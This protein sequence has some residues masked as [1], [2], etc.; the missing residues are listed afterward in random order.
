VDS[1]IIVVDIGS[2]LIGDEEQATRQDAH[3]EEQESAFAIAD[4]T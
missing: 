4:E 2:F 1:G 3:Y